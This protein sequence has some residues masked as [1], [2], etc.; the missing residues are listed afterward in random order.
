MSVQA[1]KQLISGLVDEVWNQHD[2]DT[3]GRYFGP[4]LRE[5]IAEHRR[6]LLTG[7]PDLRV[8]VDGGLIAEGDLV[9]ARLTLE[10]THRG[11]FAGQAATGRVVT[12]S[13]IR[14]Y[15]VADGKVVETWAMQDRLAL[16]QGVGAIAG[17]VE[18]NWAG[19]GP[20]DGPR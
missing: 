4:G 14:I 12:W 18:V 7:F 15:Q 6:Q 10:G 3:V 5:E 8:T 11:T 2:A 19:G 9:V 1:N 17:P 20:P 13:S 16:L